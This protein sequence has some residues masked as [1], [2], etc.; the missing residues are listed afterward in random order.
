M[1]R[2]RYIVGFKLAE[3]LGRGLFVVFCTYRLPLKEAGEFGLV[4]T[5]LSL[6]AFALSYERHI[7]VMRE[8]AGARPAHIHQRLCETLRFQLLHAGWVLPLLAL[9]AA[10]W[11]GWPA[12]QLVL[13]L[14]ILLAE[15]VANQAY[16]VVL[17]EARRVSLLFWAALRSISLPLVAVLG[18]WHLKEHF[19]LVWM[20]NAWAALSAIFLVLMIGA[21]RA[22]APRPD[23]TNPK[24][25]LPPKSA[26]AM[27]RES[28]LHFVIGAV[29]VAALQF[30]RVIVGLS[31]GS[32]A[33]GLYFRHV[34]LAALLMQF[35]NV[36]F[37]SRVAP[38]VYALVRD[39]QPAR[40]ESL[41]R[42]EYRR[43]ALLT[44]S[45]ATLALGLDHAYDLPSSRFGLVH[46]YVAIL[47]LAV[48]LRTA[49]DFVGLLM[50]AR[51]QD[52]AVLRNQAGAVCLGGIFLLFLANAL[53]LLG[54]LCGALVAPFVYLFLNSL[55]LHRLRP[56]S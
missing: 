52:A 16:Q 21:W 50:L 36:V 56:A 25:A 11:F 31:L 39:C 5:L 47:G 14:P 34:T 38:G 49:A 18:A 3:V 46:E 54:A 48:L 35:F 43:F 42:M 41:I 51:A 22:N 44:L 33:I 10:L 24:S 19:S 7:A 55:S 4:A 8:V 40:A 26:T 17:I 1:T 13:L 29:A 45:G 27:Y 2:Q 20:L 15:F 9:L 53:G 6:A 37:F 23:G 30:D 32:E 12:A 28:A